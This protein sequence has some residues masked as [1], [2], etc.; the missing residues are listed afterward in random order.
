M[1]SLE[2]DDHVADPTRQPSSLGLL[3]S[4]ER[5]HA[6][7]IEQVCSATDRTLG[8]RAGLVGTLGYRA[9]EN[10]DRTDEFVLSLLGPFQQQL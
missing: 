8:G 10:H 6:S 3:S 2:P 4:E 7:F 5:L 1:L 9:A